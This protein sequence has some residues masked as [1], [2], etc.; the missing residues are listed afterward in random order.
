MGD[1]VGQVAGLLEPVYKAMKT[2]VLESKVI[3]SDDT[4]VP[5]L[6][7]GRKSTKTGRLWVNVGDKDH[8]N[9]VFDYTPD[10]K[11]AGPIN[12]LKGFQG[13]LQADAYPGYDVLYRDHGITEVGCWAHARRRFVDAKTTD[14]PKAAVALS[15]IGQLYEVERSAQ[16]LPPEDVLRMRQERSKSI[17]ASLRAWLEQC[18][19]SVLPR[20]PLGEAIRYTLNQWEALNRYLDDGDLAIDNNAAER[21]LRCVAIGRKNWTFCGSD[22]GGRRAAVLY[23]MTA[24]CKRHGI[25]TLAYIKD[26]IEQVSFS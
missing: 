9:I 26:C 7:K 17:M 10:R 23:S 22:A 14:L 5:V 6:E 1:W 21:G 18:E 20:S 12:F 8:D 13:Y 11:R 16:G 15:L 3:H 2:D 4:P 19:G 25:D 24:S